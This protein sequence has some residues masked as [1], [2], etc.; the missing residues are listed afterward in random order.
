MTTQ[1]DVSMTFDIGGTDQ[2]CQLID[3]QT[4]RP[5]YGAGTTER[6]ACGNDVT[7]PADQI[8][9]GSISGTVVADYGPTGITRWLDDNLDTEQAVTLVETVTTDGDQTYTRTWTATVLVGPITRTFTAGRQS[10]HDLSL[11]VTAEAGPPV[12][13]NA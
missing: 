13:A 12:Y 11:T 7:V 2:A 3:P 10:R 9:N 6:N 4:V 1:R 5:S 8:S